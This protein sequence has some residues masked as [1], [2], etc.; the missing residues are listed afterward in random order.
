MNCGRVN[1]IDLERSIN[2]NTILITIMFANNEIGTIQNIKEIGRIARKYNIIFHTDSVQAM[3]NIKI[4]VR[5]LNIDSLSMSAHK[6]YGPKGVGALYMRNGVKFQKIQDGGHQENDKRAGTENT[7][8]IVGLGKAL[9][10]A[11]ISLGE[12]NNHLKISKYIIF[13]YYDVIYK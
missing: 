13:C 3:G 1:I 11:D 9:E 10:I 5:A 2:R 7:A 4:D 8:G 6:F 12:Y